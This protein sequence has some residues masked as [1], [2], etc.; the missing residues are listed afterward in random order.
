M[1]QAVAGGDLKVFECLLQYGILLDEMNS[2][3]HFIED[4]ATNKAVDTLIKQYQCTKIDSSN[5]N[6]FEAGE[7]KFYCA[8]C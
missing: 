7:T 5:K 8:I 1:H 4:L 6:P 2:R 3:K